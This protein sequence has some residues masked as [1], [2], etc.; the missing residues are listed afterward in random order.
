MLLT[1]QNQYLSVG[2]D[3]LQSIVYF[4]EISRPPIEKNVNNRAD[5]LCNL[6]FYFF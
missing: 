6:A 3:N 5:Y 1:F 4:R 2:T